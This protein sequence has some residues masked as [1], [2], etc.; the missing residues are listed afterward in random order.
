MNVA[1]GFRL[2]LAGVFG[3]AA[4]AK[5]LSPGGAFRSFVAALID[6]APTAPIVLATQIVV[7]AAE[8]VV[9]LGL[10]LCPHRRWSEVV[11]GLLLVAF[12]VALIVE[13]GRDCGCFGAARLSPS[14]HR[15]G[16]VL[17]WVAWGVVIG[18][19]RI[20]AKLAGETDT[21]TK[22]AGAG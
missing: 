4:M 10:V 21:E 13:P 7:C 19:R 16:L 6:V 20:G 8:G 22:I 3:V 15:G 2:L 5:T 12:T 14:L 9:A 1:T 17:L 11:A 18:R